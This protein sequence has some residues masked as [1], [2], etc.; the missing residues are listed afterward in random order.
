MP[1]SSLLNTFCDY[2]VAKLC[3]SGYNEADLL[4]SYPCFFVQTS[5]FGEFNGFKSASVYKMG[6][7]EGQDFAGR[8]ATQ[9]AS[10]S[11]NEI[12]SYRNC[13]LFYFSQGTAS[14]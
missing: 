2:R 5:A 10:V 9:A 8:V 3:G 14:L 11:S 6:Q 4:N 7:A 1:L 13:V 12:L